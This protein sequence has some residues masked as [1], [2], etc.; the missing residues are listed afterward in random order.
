[1]SLGEGETLGELTHTGKQAMCGE[2]QKAA[3]CKRKRETSREAQ[4]AY[5]LI[6]AYGTLR[7]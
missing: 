4:R 5:T 6:K 3:I 1:M 2:S 7:K